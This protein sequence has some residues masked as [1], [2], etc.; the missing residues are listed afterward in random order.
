VSIT[1]PRISIVTPSFNQAAYL[2]ETIQSV[3]NQG[4]QNLEYVVIDGG[5]SDGSAEIIKHYQKDLHFWVS[6]KD[7]GHGHG[8]NKGFARTSGEIMAW[9]N[10]DDKYTAWS[11]QV[12]SEIF[13]LFPHV[14]WI[15]GFNSW[16]TDKG[17]MTHA[18]RCPKNIFDFLLGNYAWIQQESVFWRRSLWDKAGG[19]IN[20]DYRLMIDGEL[21]T[22]FFLYADLYSVDCILGGY[23][24]H[25]DTRA[26]ANYEACLQEMH[27]AVSRL[28]R[29]CSP[30]RRQTLARL[31]LVR[32]FERIP[33]LRRLPLSQLARKVLFPSAF[34]DAGYKN[35]F[36]D[37]GEWVERKL[38]FSL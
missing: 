11:F 33:L 16:W 35:I 17:A 14:D 36:Y 23:R 10:S 19:F 30:E 28:M 31:K 21:W 37:H 22:R 7:S 34:N 29:N 25:S 15:V 38:Q 27:R 18:A 20:E 9:L 12:V 8:L 6:E 32:D 1:V 2:E 3:L 4:Y 13:T 5:S 24:V 26:S